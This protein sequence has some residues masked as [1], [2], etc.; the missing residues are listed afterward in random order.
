[1][2]SF[3]I[4]L[5][6]N[7]NVGK[8][9]IFNTLTGMHQHTGNWSGKT[10][11]CTSGEYVYNENKYTVYDIPGTYSLIA[12]SKEE[13]LARDFICFEKSDLNVIV[14][15]AVC[16]ERNLN[17]LLQILEVSSKTIICVNLLDEAQKRGI[18]INL[19]R[20]E[21]ILKVPVIGT[22]ARHNIGIDKLL[23]TIEGNVLD[24]KIRKSYI[25]KYSEDIEA[26]INMLTSVIDCDGSRFIALE[27]L[28]NSNILEKI[29]TKLSIKEELNFKLKEAKQYLLNKD[30][31]I[32]DLE[33]EITSKIVSTAS[34]IYAEVTEKCNNYSEKDRKIDKIL[35]SK[36][37]GIP[38]MLM[39]LFVV[40]WITIVGANYPSKLL[41]NLFN[42]IGDYFLRFLEFVNLKANVI[43]L[44]Y[45][46]VYR[47]VTW[48]IAVMLPP[49]AIFFPLFTFLE[50]LGYLPRIAFNLDRCFS[51]CNA[52][53][54]Q[55]LTMCMGFGCNAVGVTGARIID[56]KRERLIAILTNCFVPCNG[57]FPILISLSSAFFVGNSIF[58]PLIS[59][60]ILT[61]LI[62]LGIIMTLLVSKVLSI[63][64]LKGEN[65]SFVLELPA[66]RSPDVF[67]IIINSIFDRVLFVLKRSLVVALPAGI[68]IWVI[69]NVTVFNVSIISILSNILNPIGKIFGMDG[70]ILV[71]FILGFPANEIVIP[72][73]LMGYL[74][75]GILVDIDNYN[76][77]KQI[78]I[79]NGW[80]YITAICVMIFT[81]FHFPCSTTFLSIKHETKSIKWAL[82]SLLIPTTIGFIM[83]F[84]VKEISLIF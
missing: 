69:S 80:T 81:I 79:D 56:S 72:I 65:S 77:L 41:F 45:D 34:L 71:G 50:D 62:L 23:S 8:S 82:L 44:L 48:I 24:K 25:L 27:L 7:P 13:E 43:S 46:G 37:T 9:T 76:L 17:L 33:E 67:K 63:T 64:I 35:T 11:G 18:K 14:C 6:G 78:L 39:M 15:D 32:S 20:L 59:A 53:G 4:T 57:R 22:D 49:M 12:H 5:S 74:N 55:A 31:I 28:R 61:G 3:V 19:K 40:F 1:M 70:M 26:A 83:C 47:V 68:I 73:I 30:I 16:L 52:C 66:Y 42:N 29:K 60:L 38:I 75:T 10:V 21:K 36:L 58:S 51:K 54:K 2:K 84:L